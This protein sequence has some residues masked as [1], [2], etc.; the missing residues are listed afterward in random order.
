ML[1]ND[2]SSFICHLQQ[3]GEWF[4]KFNNSLRN[5]NLTEAAQKDFH[6]ALI[7]ASRANPWFTLENSLLR[8]EYLSAYLSGNFGNHE[9]I[10]GSITSVSGKNIAIVIKDR[11]PFGF[12]P[13]FTALYI[14]GCQISFVGKDMNES[15]FKAFSGII[16]LFDRNAG[17]AISFHERLPKDAQ[18]LIINE[19]SYPEEMIAKYFNNKAVYRLRKKTSVAILDGSE[20][21]CQ[22][23][24]LAKD[25]FSF[26]GMGEGNVKKLFIPGG[27]DFSLF[28][29]TSENYHEIIQHNRYANHF[30]Y[31]QSVFLFNREKFLSN[32]F[33]ALKEDKKLFAPEGVLFYETYSGKDDLN[34][35]LFAV[36]DQVKFIYTSDKFGNSDCQSLQPDGELFSFLNQI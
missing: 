30:Q 36:N 5:K 29:K 19:D 32:D 6:Q 16:E 4:R 28:F 10:T 8:I 26:F 24:N 13:L 25:V 34:K 9:S 2:K 31:N 1:I 21:D 11:I 22:L 7:I 18:A 17:E 14:S 27:Y 3:A 15:L 20:T 33:L 35:K 23:E 12:F